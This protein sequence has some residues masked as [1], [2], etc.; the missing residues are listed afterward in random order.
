MR[1]DLDSIR[2]Q[3]GKF[4][5]SREQLIAQLKT[6]NDGIARKVRVV[7]HSEI[8]AMNFNFGFS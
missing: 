4:K 5:N 7:I 6:L 8:T 2:E 1:A 3:Q